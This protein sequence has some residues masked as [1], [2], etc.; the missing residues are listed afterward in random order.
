LGLL[1]SFVVCLFTSFFSLAALLRSIGPFQGALIMFTES[2]ILLVYCSESP[3]RK[4]LD[5]FV[6]FLIMMSGG[7]CVW[8]I[9]FIAFVKEQDWFTSVFLF[10]FCVL[11]FPVYS[12]YQIDQASQYHLRELTQAIVGFLSFPWKFVTCAKKHHPVED[13]SF[14]LVE[15]ESSADKEIASKKVTI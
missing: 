8:A 7:V 15:R 13:P 4:R 2:T 5:P 6:S 10:F 1:A 9:G 14:V 3:N 11:G 12:A